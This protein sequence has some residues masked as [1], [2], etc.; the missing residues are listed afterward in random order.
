MTLGTRIKECRLKAK[1]S[2]EKVAELVGVSRQAVTKWEA[3]QSSPNTENLFRLAEIFGT[4][5][6]FLITSENDNRSV[7]EQVYQM[8]KDD[9]ARKEAEA[10]AQRLRSCRC[11]WAV[12]GGYLLVFL[13]CKVFWS[14]GEDMTVMG[15]LFGTSPYHHEYLFGW[16]ISKRLYFYASLLSILS[17]AI[18]MRRLALTT[19]GAFTIGLPMGEYLG[20]IPGLVPEGYHYGWAIWG[21]LFVGSIFLG[22]WLQR[23]QAEE[24]SFQSKKLRRWCIVTGLYIVAV[25]AFVLLNIPPAQY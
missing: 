4:T 9:E 23:F 16:L 7:A 11:T 21:L 14:T 17:A 3:D 19:L 13:L 25:I 8:F 10:N 24:L 2:Q 22:I 5:V 15:W 12:A 1:L 6:D 18:G 20:A